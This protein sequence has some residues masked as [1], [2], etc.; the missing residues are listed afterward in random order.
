[1]LFV[2]AVLRRRDA[3]FALLCAGLLFSLRWLP[4]GF[5]GASAARSLHAKGRVVA[6][7]DAGIQTIQLIMVAV[8]P[9]IALV[10]AL[11]YRWRPRSRIAEA[12]PGGPIE[13][14]RSR[15]RGRVV[16][17]QDAAADP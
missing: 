9:F 10:G 3:L 8:A 14:A 11:V 5:E 12:A 7:D 15:G 1:M 4:T 13:G 16:T 6:V 2:S 17:A